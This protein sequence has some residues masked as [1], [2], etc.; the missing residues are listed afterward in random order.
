MRST[1]LFDTGPIKTPRLQQ[2]HHRIHITICSGIL[3]NT[4]CVHKCIYIYCKYYIYIYILNYIYYIIYNYNI[5]IYK[6]IYVVSLPEILVCSCMSTGAGSTSV[7]GGSTCKHQAVLETFMNYWDIPVSFSE[8]YWDV[9][10]KL[11]QT[12]RDTKWYP[13]ICVNEPYTG[14]PSN[15]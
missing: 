14:M 7:W 13:H 10:R 1:S 11:P 6:I 15:V 2:K 9:V 3:F 5:Y 8:T 12:H 4:L